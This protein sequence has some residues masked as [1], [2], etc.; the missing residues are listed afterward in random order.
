MFMT[1]LPGVPLIPLSAKSIREKGM[2]QVDPRLDPEEVE[3]IA[4]D[5]TGWRM[6][7]T[8]IC[9]TSG[10]QMKSTKVQEVTIGQ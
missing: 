1:L 8:E 2:P 6:M 9:R 10:G 3:S 5:L 7:V 4:R